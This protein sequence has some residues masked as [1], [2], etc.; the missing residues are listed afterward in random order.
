MSGVIYTENPQRDA[1]FDQQRLQEANSSR[2]FIICDKCHGKIYR[3]DDM[4]EGDVYYD[5]DG[6]VFCEDCMELYLKERKRV[7]T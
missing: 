6:I 5:F 7:L 4:Y 1:E 2:D 3:E